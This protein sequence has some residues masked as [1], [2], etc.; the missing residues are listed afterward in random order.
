[1]IMRAVCIYLLIGVAVLLSLPVVSVLTAWA[2]GP[3]TWATVRHQ[4]DT[5]MGVYAWSSLRLALGVAVGSALLGGLTAAAVALLEFPGRRWLGAALLLPMAMPAYVLA[6]VMTDT[7]QFSGPVQT[8]WRAWQG[9]DAA[10]LPDVRSLGGAVVLMV[11]CLYPYVYLLVRASLADQGMRLMEAARMLGASWPRRLLTVAL[12]VARPALV[13]GVALTLMETLA[14]YG[15]GSYFGLTTVTTG[16]YRAWLSMDDRLAA[17]QLASLLLVVVIGLLWLEQRARRG[18]SLAMNRPGASASQ[19]APLRLRGWAGWA[20]S[21][22]CALPVLLGFVLPTVRLLQ[23]L[24]QEHQHGEFGLPWAQFAQ[25]CLHSLQ[26]AGGA[27]VLTV[28]LAL[29]LVHLVRT[30]GHRLLKGATVLLSMGYA[31][32]GA[33]IA[34]GLLWPAGWLQSV[35]PAE[36]L[37]PQRP[38]LSPAGLMTG[39]LFG[40]MY[41]YLVRFSSVALQTIE[42]GDAHISRTLDES[43]RLMGI[44]GWA[45]WWKVHLPLLWRPALAATTLVFVDVMKELPATLVLRP[46]DSDTLAVMAYQLARDERLGEAALPSLAMVVV[47]LV[48]VLMLYRQLSKARH[49]PAH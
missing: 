47:G 26:L 29:V 8:W 1:M 10:R 25:W 39:T 48:P 33:V 44:S 27:A 15:V 16:I 43:A 37:D 5:V 20:V 18:M 35:W 24:W 40:L 14:D 28:L 11:L 31:V 3:E 42:S 2:G 4:F 23:L 30:T 9:A 22:G 36:W 6:Y 12:P 38:L 17:A 34:V 49:A 21:L 13:A 32:P 45:L 19:V 41:A 7:L 46:F